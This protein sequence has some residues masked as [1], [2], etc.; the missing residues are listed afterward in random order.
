[1]PLYTHFWQP[2]RHSNL[3][4]TILLAD[5]TTKTST[6]KGTTDCYFTTDEG[7]RSILGLT[8]I[9]FIEGLSHCIL[10]LTA[11]S[12]TQNFTAFPYTGRQYSRTVPNVDI[13]GSYLPHLGFINPVFANLGYASPN[14]V[15]C[16][17]D[18]RLGLSPWNTERLY[19]LNGQLLN[20]VC[21]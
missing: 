2:S 21:S 1:M 20:V 17:L 10:S 9:Y 4:H 11:I 15:Q 13:V 5:G 14:L 16:L 19:A 8:D 6:F 12:P 18:S 7:Q 3:P